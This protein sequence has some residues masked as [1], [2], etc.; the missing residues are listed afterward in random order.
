MVSLFQNA[1]RLRY[2]AGCFH[3][4]E[5]LIMSPSV[6][7]RDKVICVNKMEANEIAN[8]VSRTAHASPNP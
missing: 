5:R 6:N 2:T 1:L 7:G 4:T 8:K 3:R